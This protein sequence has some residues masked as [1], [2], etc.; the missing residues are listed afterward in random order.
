VQFGDTW[1]LVQTVLGHR[2][3]TTTMDV[4]LEPFRHLDVE[5]LLEQ[6]AGI[7]VAD[8]LEAAC[9]AHPRVAGDPLA[10]TAYPGGRG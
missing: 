8:L 1:Q 4:Y 2:S 3:V 7:P 10:D 5:L 9:Q 6:A